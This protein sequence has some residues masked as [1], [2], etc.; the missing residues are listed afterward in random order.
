MNVI[1]NN[2]FYLPL[3]NLLLF[4][5]HLLFNN[6]GLGIIALTVLMRLILLP[7][8]LPTMRYTK[9]MQDL[10]PAMDALKKQYGKDKKRLMEEQARLYKEHGVNPLSGCLPNIIQ[11]AVV[12]TL[13][14]VFIHG[15]QVTEVSSQFLIWD[16]TK[17]DKFY[18]IPLLA[19][20]S[21]FI[22]S[23]MLTPAVEKHPEK[24]AGEDKESVEDMASTMQSQM[25]FLMPIMTTMIGVALPSG[26]GLY[27]VVST[28]M[29][30][31]QQYYTS[32]LGGL[33]RWI[34]IF[35]KQS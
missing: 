11:I 7:L 6:L 12:I 32:G 15:L 33:R 16:I 24:V 23:A 34:K 27:W 28:V 20:I 25:L 8:S 21:Q 4:L 22:Y 5:S 18:I 30:V 14:Q 9:K 35:K 3:F 2:F 1:W 29:Q 17:P 26:L 13:Y 31:I 19:G 10:K